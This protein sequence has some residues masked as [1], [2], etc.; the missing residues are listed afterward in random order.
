MT[1]SSY[2]SAKY[3]YRAEYDQVITYVGKH[4]VFHYLIMTFY[5]YD[6]YDRS[7]I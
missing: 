2:H 4:V 3:T 5:P 7:T 6:S 1:L